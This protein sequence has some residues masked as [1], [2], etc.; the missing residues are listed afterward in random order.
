VNQ[1]ARAGKKYKGLARNR[2]RTNTNP[3]DTEANVAGRMGV[4]ACSGNGTCEEII[5]GQERPL[6]AQGAKAPTGQELPLLLHIDM[7]PSIVLG[8]ERNHIDMNPS[9]VKRFL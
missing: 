1:N 6:D 5:R 9:I 2:T 7:N 8:F 3:H 4:R